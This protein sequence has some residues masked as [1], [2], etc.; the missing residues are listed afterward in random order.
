MFD[1]SGIEIVVKGEVSLNIDL[2]FN[3]SIQH[4]FLVA[5]IPDAPI[6]LGIDFIKKFKISIN[7]KNNTIRMGA[8]KVPLLIEEASRKHIGTLT[9]SPKR[10]LCWSIK[11]KRVLMTNCVGN[12]K[13]FSVRRGYGFINCQTTNNDV[14]VHRTAIVNGS[15]SQNRPGLVNGELVYFDVVSG[16]QGLPE[17]SNIILK[18][19]A[20]YDHAQTPHRLRTKRSSHDRF[21]RVR[22]RKSSKQN[23]IVANVNKKISSAANGY[24]VFERNL[25]RPVLIDTGAFVSVISSDVL[26]ADDK[27][28]HQLRSASG[29]PLKSVGSVTVDIDLG[30]KTAF[31]HQ[32]SVTENSNIGI[33]IGLDI[34]TSQGLIINGAKDSLEHGTCATRLIFSNPTS[35]DMGCFCNDNILEYSHDQQ[36]ESIESL[37]LLMSTIP[38]Q[39]YTEPEPIES[40]RTLMSTVHTDFNAHLPPHHAA[41]KHEQQTVTESDNLEF[42]CRRAL[43]GLPRLTFGPAYHE[44]PRHPY[45]VDIVL[46]EHISSMRQKARTCTPKNRKILRDTFLDL[47]D[48]NVVQRGSPTH[49]CPT[50]I[51]AKKDGKPRV[52]VDYTRLNN[53]TEWINYPLPQMNTLTS[54]VTPKHKWFSV[55]DLKEAYFSLPLTERASQYAGII[56]PDG[57]FVPKRCQFGL[58]N[59]PFKFCELI[60]D[61]THGLKDF[62]FTYLDD[63]LIFF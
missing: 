16:H 2:G 4:T 29:H 36:L 58:R 47:V 26:S 61:V 5:E 60:D 12:V 18:T 35:F 56:T 19:N 57:A 22:S 10:D 37:K 20:R 1:A 45:K 55:I 6:I 17:A 27:V 7:F 23:Q 24:Y 21:S 62:I 30:F 9:S 33:I 43:S 15:F 51:V 59:A 32:F 25:G 28:T 50:T 54:T 53:I 38:D 42:E 48:R 11:P 14:F 52:C 13:W 63:F 40:I 46:T 31:S 41:D 44:P 49:V 39:H 34:L 3:T 8:E